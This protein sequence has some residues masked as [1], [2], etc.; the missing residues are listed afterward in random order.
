MFEAVRALEP[1]NLKITRTMH[2]VNSDDGNQI[3]YTDHIVDVGYLTYNLIVSQ[4]GNPQ[5]KDDDEKIMMINK[6]FD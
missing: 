6:Y 4:I 2:E 5:N 1:H 3:D